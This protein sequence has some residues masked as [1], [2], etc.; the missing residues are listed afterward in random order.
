VRQPLSLVLDLLLLI[1]GALLGLA[2]NYVTNQGQASP[3]LDFVQRNALWLLV[4]ILAISV[5]VRIWIYRLDRPPPPR[6]NWTG[7]KPPYPGLEAFTAEDAGVFFGRDAEIAQLLDRLHSTSRQPNRFVCVV[8]PSGAGKS[9]LVQAGVIPNLASRRTTWVVV[10][11]FVPE[12]DPF[13]NLARALA[14]ALSEPLDAQATAAELRTSGMNALS[15]LLDRLRDRASGRGVR[16][17]LVIDQA[18][19]LHT[20]TSSVDAESFLDLMRALMRDS[21]GTWAI[22]TFRSEFITAFLES[23]YADLLADPVV[24]GRLHDGALRLIIEKPAKEAGLALGPGVVERLV[25]DADADTGSA[26]PLLAYTLQLLWNRARDTREVALD[27]YEAVGGVAGAIRR[28]ADNV[29]RELGG[30]DVAVPVLLKFVT[31]SETNEPT[32]RRVSASSLSEDERRVMQCFVDARLLSTDDAGGEV[33][34]QVAHEALFKQW[35][36]LEQ[37]IEVGRDHL[38]SRAELERWALD[39]EKSGRQASYLLR[40]ERLLAAQEWLASNPGAAADSP[41][42]LKF[43]TTSLRSDQAAL[44]R[45]SDAVARRALESIERDPDQSIP[46]AIA[47]IEECAATPIACR[48]LMT[49]LVSSRTHALLQHDD[50][51]RTVVWSPDS[52]LVVT[53]DH[54]GTVRIWLAETGAELRSARVHDG[55]IR[56]IAWS[57]DGSQLATGCEDGSAKVLSAETLDVVLVLDGHDQPVHDVSWSPDGHRVVT[58]SHDLTAKVWNA[59]D[60]ARL[61]VLRGHSDWVRTAS[62]SPDGALLATGSCDG[63]IRLWTSAGEEHGVMHG[64]RD[65]VEEVAWSPNGSA[66][67]SASSDLTIR[68]WNGEDRSLRAELRGHADWVQALAWSPDGRNL[69]S[70][71]RDR[72]VRVWEPASPNAEMAVLRGHTDW[73]HDVGWSRDGRLVASASYDRTARLWNADS[74]AERRILRGHTDRVRSVAVAPDGRTVA[75]ASADRSVRLWD[76]ASGVEVRLFSVD[77]EAFHVAWSP[78]GHRLTAVTRDRICCVWDVA[79]AE[80]VT[81]LSGHTNWPEYVTWAPDGKTVATGSNDRTVI[82]WHADTGERIQTLHGHQG[83]VRGVAWSQD[84]RLVTASHDRTAQVWDPLS[85]VPGAVLRGHRGFVEDVDWSPD[86]TQVATASL[87]RTVRIWNADTGDCIQVLDGHDDAVQAVAWSPDG[88]R[89]ATASSDRTA[90]VWSPRTGEELA[91]VAVH[92]KTIDDLS[93][94]PDG[95]GLVTAARDQTARIWDANIEINTLLER[96]RSR[97][98]RRLTPEERQAA[99]LPE[100][101]DGVIGNATGE[102]P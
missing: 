81:V 25:A 4:G 39:W 33:T 53:G 72:T 76:T 102:Q 20:L 35:A 78:D 22:A 27:D 23:G 1:L 46:L 69:V 19:E 79:T 67:A 85:G 8:G 56:T 26:L 52:T 96:A 14:A 100:E 101:G 7:A 82:V 32:R 37:A 71:S 2:A 44:E 11:P 10:G 47:A 3:I 38:R 61:A 59:D 88:G 5:V 29:A 50:V 99:L 24:L 43:I 58:A 64:H 40:Q 63:T 98:V 62:F 68:V 21:P 97:A 55:W 75:T 41:L 70:A 93:W 94:L 84:G 54:G 42:A 95:H 51:V 34:V 86:G 12:S 17:L 6:R 73:V 28:Q 80:I 57:P 31:I 74:V 90:R 18:E 77:N 91:V 49:A 45:L 66:L 15:G 92:D 36:P 65:W 13:R 87:D 89:V 9:S 30:P 83:W 16:A 60:G 48:A